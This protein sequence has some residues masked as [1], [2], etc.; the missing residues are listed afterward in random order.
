MNA[1]SGKYTNDKLSDLKFKIIAKNSNGEIIYNDTK[2]TDSNGNINIADEDYF[3]VTG[4]ITFEIKCLNTPKQF[5][6]MQDITVVVNRDQH[7]DQTITVDQVKTSSNVKASTEAIR[8]PHNV[9]DF[10]YNVNVDIPFVQKTIKMDLNK[11]SSSSDKINLQGATFTLT[12]P[13]GKH[14]EQE[15]TNEEGKTEFSSDVY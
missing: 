6:E 11:I 12:Q 2:T 10:T 1:Y 4:E 9:S 5:K 14:T 3:R 7:P 13:D 8:D 15:T